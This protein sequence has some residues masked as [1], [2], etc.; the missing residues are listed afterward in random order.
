MA[1]NDTA[2]TMTPDTL[3]VRDLRQL[4]TLIHSQDLTVREL[5]R[6]LFDLEDQDAPVIRHLLA[7]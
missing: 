1:T 6:R 2:P 5:R 3:T 7:I 4:L